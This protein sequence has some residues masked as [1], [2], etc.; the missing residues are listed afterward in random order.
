MDI[1]RKIKALREKNGK[2]QEDLALDLGVSRQTINKWET[3]KAQPN[4]EN[5]KALCSIFAVSSEYFL[6]T[7]ISDTNVDVAE[8]AATVQNKSKRKRR[9]LIACAIAVGLLCIISTFGSV[10]W[11]FSVFSSNTGDNVVATHN[12]EIAGFIL[13]LITAIITFIAEI[14]IMF[15]I[16]RKRQK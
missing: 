10:I 11:G 1:G 13:L 3:N 2:S 9:I 16:L 6:G 5:I 12:V 7:E 8:T 15:F 14:V 4:T